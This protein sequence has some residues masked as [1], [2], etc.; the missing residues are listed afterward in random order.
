MRFFW[1]G[2]RQDV[3]V[4]IRECAHCIL[5]DKRIRHHS[6][7]LFSWPVTAPMFVL[8][9]DLWSPGSTV[10]SSGH[11]HLLSAMCD[12]TQFVVSVPVRTTHAHNLALHYATKQMKVLMKVKSEL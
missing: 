3:I 4:W 1:P 10:S 5:A 7:V 11:N 6:E 12:L 2:C 8:H 9:C